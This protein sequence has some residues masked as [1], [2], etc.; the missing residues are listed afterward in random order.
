MWPEYADI[1]E[2]YPFL[3]FAEYMI[4]VLQ[5]EKCDMIIAL[6]HMMKYNDIELAKK[7]PEI[8]LILG[9]HDHL[10]VH[11]VVNNSIFIKSGTNFKHFSFLKVM[12]RENFSADEMLKE[13]QFLLKNK[14]WSIVVDLV[15]VTHEK[16]NIVPD[17]ELNHYIE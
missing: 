11:E 2:Y 5:G 10:I 6:T 13:G 14:K 12:K 17:E 16:M 7:F 3:E 8:D 15:E 4:K 9:G 1:C